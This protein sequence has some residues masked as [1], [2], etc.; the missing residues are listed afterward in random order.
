MKSIAKTLGSA[1]ILL[2]TFALT[3]TDAQAEKKFV[4]KK[5][6]EVGKSPLGDNT[7]TTA[8]G[9]QYKEIKVGTGATPKRN[10][11]VW[12]HW[13]GWLPDGKK[14]H[15]TRDF[16]MPYNFL[17]G[18]G[19][20]VI[21]AWEEAL[22]TMKVGGKRLLLVPPQLGYGSKGS[23]EIPPDTTV[24][25]EIELVQ[26]GPKYK[27]EPPAQSTKDSKDAKEA[28]DAKNPKV[29]KGGKNPKETKEAKS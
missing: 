17:F 3:T 4:I 21:P 1:L 29:P 13:T 22:S 23:G 18:F 20:Q 10:D 15:C 6:G 16:G 8:S 11:V 2:G 5:E 19:N 14:F 25:Y 27:P 12:I 26:I 7:I 9:L 24:K 28:K